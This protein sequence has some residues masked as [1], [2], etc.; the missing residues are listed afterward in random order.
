MAL[1]TRVPLDPIFHAF[2]VPATVERPDLEDAPIPTT[3]V[4][5]TWR[6]EDA[7]D[8]GQVRRIESLK[9]LRIRHDQI[10]KVPTGTLV[11]APEILG[12]PIKRWRVDKCV[13]SEPQ[14]STYAVIFSPDPHATEPE[15]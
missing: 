2:G 6:A 1:D 12:G 3:V 11:Y 10:P 15:L 9:L 13:D 14:V 4:W 8:L 7:V 5:R